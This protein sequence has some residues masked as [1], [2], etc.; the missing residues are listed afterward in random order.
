MRYTAPED[1]ALSPAAAP[2][3]VAAELTAALPSPLAP[4]SRSE[5]DFEVVL[6]IAM[7]IIMQYDNSLLCWRH[8]EYQK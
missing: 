4:L 6:R 8:E 1:G 7:L 2:A 5:L 3:V